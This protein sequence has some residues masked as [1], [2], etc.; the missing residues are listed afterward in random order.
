MLF[1]IIAHKFVQ[2]LENNVKIMLF[3]IK[4]LH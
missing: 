4:V 1:G 3:D 2:V